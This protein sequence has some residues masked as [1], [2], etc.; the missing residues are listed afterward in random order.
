LVTRRPW[1]PV[2]LA[3]VLLAGCSSDTGA[4]P[5]AAGPNATNATDGTDATTPEATTATT[6][7]DDGRP[8]VVL[9]GDSV[10]GNLAPGV[11]A[12]LGD[13]VSA[14]YLAQARIS[15]DASATQAWRSMVEE[16]DPDLIVIHVG[17]WEV[18]SPTFRPSRPGWY[19]QYAANVLDPFV[20]LLTS[21]G[22]RVLF[23]G[24]GAARHEQK[25]V[26]LIHLNRQL[27]ALDERN[28]DVDFLN[29]GTYVNGPTGGFTE[30]LPGPGGEPVRIHRT[31]DLGLHLCP[32]GVVRLA[33][34]VIEWID[35]NLDED[36]T[37]VAGWD[38][39]DWTRPPLLEK[40]EQ[41]P[42]VS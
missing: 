4:S 16:Q 37:P 11:I 24:P 20:A 15:G 35:E 3:A 33:T 29:S 22:A 17:S 8:H 18:L 14:E 23:I 12:G 2:L 1:L 36:I 26:N 13:A 21:G 40:P 34:P 39:A 25:T 38:H 31:D 28:P 9:G 5:N 42:P 19:P 6:R 32:A 27:V 7:P 10:M 41:C 30:V